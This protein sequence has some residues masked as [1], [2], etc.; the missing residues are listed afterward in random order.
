[1]RNIKREDMSRGKGLMTLRSLLTAPKREVHVRSTAL[2]KRA[3]SLY[4]SKRDLYFAFCMHNKW[5]CQ[6]NLA[7]PTLVHT[8]ESDIDTPLYTP[9]PVHFAASSLSVCVVCTHTFLLCWQK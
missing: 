9:L 2:K 5:S 4:C 7:R 6:D 8:S 3:C 1:M